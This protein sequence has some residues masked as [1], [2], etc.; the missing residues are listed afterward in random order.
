MWK[1]RLLVVSPFT[2]FGEPGC[3][4]PREKLTRRCGDAEDVSEVI[5]KHEK[6]EENETNEKGARLSGKSHAETRRCGGCLRSF[7]N[8]AFFAFFAA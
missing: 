3:V 1:S 7:K 8:Y 2:D 5:L 6:H 4:S